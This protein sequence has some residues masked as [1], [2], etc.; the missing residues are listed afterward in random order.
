[1]PGLAIA[2]VAD[3]EVV[4]AQGHGS[5][6]ATGV[7][8]AHTLFNL[9]SVSKSVTAMALLGQRDAGLLALDDSVVAHVPYFG[10][11]P[12]STRRAFTSSTCCCTRRGSAIGRR[13]HSCGWRRSRAASR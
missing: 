2:V 7:V 12:G 4:Y 5:A 9:A 10:L 3:G 6:G 11:D 1:V 8:D 13:S